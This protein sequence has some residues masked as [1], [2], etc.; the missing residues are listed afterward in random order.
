VEQIALKKQP[1]F[2]K[3]LGAEMPPKRIV[4]VTSSLPKELENQYFVDN[5][6]LDDGRTIKEVVSFDIRHVAIKEVLD[7]DL[8][9]IVDAEVKAAYQIIQTPCIVEHA[10]LIYEEYR[11]QSYPGGLT[12]PMW[13]ALRENFVKET[14]GRGRR[15]IARAVVG[16]CSGMSTYVFVGE[17][18]GTISAEPKGDSDFYWDTVF[19]PDRSDGKPGEKTY[20]EIIADPALGLPCKM[21]LSQ[22][23]K[24]MRAFVDHYVH[25]RTAELWR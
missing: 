14:N 5:M 10:G 17:T 23:T 6:H 24:A 7:V 8:K 11:D 19:I 25:E 2:F 3:E 15:A 20:A 4:Y 18:L 1:H 13:N 12:K 22:S 9:V 21:S 16:Y